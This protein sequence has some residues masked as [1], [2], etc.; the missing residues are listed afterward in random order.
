VKSAIAAFAEGREEILEVDVPYENGRAI[1]Q[2]HESGEVLS[3]IDRGDHLEM[4]VRVPKSEAARLRKL[5]IAK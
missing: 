3:K 5:G 4:R 1:A 2:L